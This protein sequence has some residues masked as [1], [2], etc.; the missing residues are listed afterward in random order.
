MKFKEIASRVTGFSVPVFGVSWNP[1]EAER[2]I[3]R[4]LLTALEDK[5]VLY[6]PTQLEMPE[7]CIQ[8]V[9]E[10]RHLLTHELPG[11]KEDSPLGI[12]IRGM[13]SAC[14]KFLDTIQADE[15]ITRFGMSHGHYASWVFLSAIGELR[16]VC[17]L[18]LAAIATQYGL[19]IEKDLA[20]IIP[21]MEE[22]E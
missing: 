9:I 5:R 3:A 12:H 1:P 11:L 20:S 13:R 10:I 16:G 15:R 21:T 19:D 17:G 4:R 22:D 18:H 7:H 8:S 2:S 14:R 6:N